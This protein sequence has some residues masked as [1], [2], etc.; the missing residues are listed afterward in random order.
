MADTG[1][2]ID[3]NGNVIDPSGKIIGNVYVYGDAQ[4]PD[5]NFAIDTEFVR[6]VGKAISQTAYN[7]KW[8]T[9]T[10]VFNLEASMTGYFTQMPEVL[11]DAL[12]HFSGNF[13]NG[14]SELLDQRIAIGDRLVGLAGDAEQ[15]EID[16][17]KTFTGYNGFIE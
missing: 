5:P 6:S 14:Y 15:K 2:T 10:S 17:I 4:G 11:Q 16:N 3:S 9:P 1:D 12:N 8:K 13:H 7:E